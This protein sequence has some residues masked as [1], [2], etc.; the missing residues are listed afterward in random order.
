VFGVSEGPCQLRNTNFSE[1]VAEVSASVLVLEALDFESVIPIVSRFVTCVNCSGSFGFSLL[2]KWGWNQQDSAFVG[3]S[4]SESWWTLNDTSYLI[5]RNCLFLK[6]TGTL[7]GCLGSTQAN[8]VVISCQFDGAVPSSVASAEL[9]YFDT[10]IVLETNIDLQLVKHRSCYVLVLDGQMP[11]SESLE[12]SHV[13]TSKSDSSAVKRSISRSIIVTGSEDTADVSSSDLS[14]D[15][16]K[17]S[18]MIVIIGVVVAI[19]VA[20]IVVS[21]IVLVWCKG[22]KKEK[23]NCDVDT[24]LDLPQ[25]EVEQAANGGTWMNEDVS[26]MFG[27]DGGVDGNG[28]WGE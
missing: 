16:S 21:V 27:G 15:T 22:S 28:I 3:V 11:P 26:A 12:T 4:A 6:Q 18:N 8:I 24:P 14:G 23:E 7:F 10:Q 25:S 5:L 20:V 19:G 2:Y 13:A 1:C 9:N 17:K